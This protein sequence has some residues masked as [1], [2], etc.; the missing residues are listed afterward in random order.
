MGVKGLSTFTMFWIHYTTLERVTLTTWNNKLFPLVKIHDKGRGG[1]YHYDN[2]TPKVTWP[3]ISLRSGWGY[4]LG[5][6]SLERSQMEACS[7]DFSICVFVYYSI[8]CKYWLP[9]VHSFWRL[10]KW[11]RPKSMINIICFMLTFLSSLC[12]SFCIQ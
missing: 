11:F 7:T 3:R 9:L 1:Y 12:F 6:G 5:I 2:P 8:S 10:S 4:P